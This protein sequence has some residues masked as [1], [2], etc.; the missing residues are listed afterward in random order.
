[1]RRTA[2]RY[3]GVSAKKTKP[4]AIKNELEG[5]KY[6]KAYIRQ[7][8]FFRSD[9][10]G[11]VISVLTAQSQNPEQIMKAPTIWALGATVALGLSYGAKAGTIT[12]LAGNPFPTAN[13]NPATILSTANADGVDDYP[14][15]GDANLTVDVRLGSAGTVTNSFGTFTV[16]DTSTTGVEMFSF[17]LNPGFV[18]AGLSLH[19]GGGNI[20][21]FYSVNDETS[22]TNEGP[23][24]CPN[25]ASG[26][27]GGLSN[28]D[29]LLEIPEPTGF[30]LTC[31]GL[32]MLFGVIRRG[33]A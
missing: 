21:N 17:N 14:G 19:D 7:G 13:Q 29:F 11:E 5:Q 6:S 31:I 22:G 12:P 9:I 24:S 10:M 15:A 8:H 32:L 27:P 16:T 30:A 23:V 1:V 3:A 2:R 26:H 20:V 4:Y 25:N 33:K 28:F 18:L